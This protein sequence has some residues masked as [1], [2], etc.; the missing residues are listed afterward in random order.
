[1]ANKHDSPIQEIA[2]ELS[3]DDVAQHFQPYAIELGA[4]VYGWNQLHDNLAD[5]FWAVLGGLNG[6]IPLAVWHSISSDRSQ[7]E[8][9]RA[10]ADARF[11]AHFPNIEKNKIK[12]AE[13]AKRFKWL[14]GET[15]KLSI[16]RNDVIHAPYWFLK[17][18]K[19]LVPNTFQGNPRAK[20]LGEVD[21]LHE[22]QWCRSTATVLGDFTGRLSVAVRCFDNEHHSWPDIP[23]LPNR[24]HKKSPKAD[25]QHSR[26]RSK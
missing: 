11:L 7:R 4:F 1:M 15:D 3:A 10:A 23:Q 8:M 12:N 25:R 13:A 19:K 14:L 5:L 20:G 18:A 24:G 16:Y 6:A 9:L 21:L 2:T 26:L 17:G 22:F